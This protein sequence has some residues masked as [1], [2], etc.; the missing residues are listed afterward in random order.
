MT[1]SNAELL[2]ELGID[3]KHKHSGN[4]KT[5]CPKCGPTRKNKKDPCLSVDIDTGLYNCHHCDFKGRVF[6][7]PKKEFVRPPARLEKLSPKSLQW[8]ESVRGISNDTLLR[9]KVTESREWIPGL[10]GE[11]NCICFNYFRNDQ[12]INIKYR[13]PQKSFKMEKDAELIFYNLQAIDGKTTAVIVEGEIDCLTMVE[14]G[15]YDCVS[16]PNGAS[17]GNQRLEYLDNCWEYFDKKEKVVI[18]TDNDEAGIS[19][20]DELARRIGKDRCYTVEYPDGCKDTNEVY[21]KHGKEAVLQMLDNARLWPLEGI[22]STEDIFP[23]IVDWFE[24]GY[25]EGTRAGLQG[26]DDLLAFAP[27]EL[28]TITG[29]PG[30]GKDEYIN[31]VISSLAQRHGWKFGMFDFEETPPQTA[32]KLMEKISG[33]AFAFR[34]NPDD[35]MSR[36]GFEQAVAMVDSH[37]YFCNTDDIAPS[38]DMIISIATSL[39]LRFGIKGI[40]I[41]PWNWIEN[42]RPASMTETEYISLSLSK[43]IRFAR[44]YGV[45]VFLIAHTT[46]IQKDKRTGKYEIPNLYSISG[47]ANFYNKTHNGITVYRDAEAGTVDVY[48]QKV[49]QS[50]NGQTGWVSYTFNTFTRQYTLQSTSL[51]GSA[52]GQPWK[53]V[54]LFRDDDEESVNEE[55]T[56]QGGQPW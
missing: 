55:E 22:M 46:K 44:K 23:V 50:W 4:L 19:L 17:K 39:V 26:L 41:N 15:I 8:F 10:Q 35:R 13:G 32:T 16:V 29:I 5:Q 40:R 56:T 12:L 1:M 28:T 42:N 27:G 11:V 18:A 37:F 7:K 6:E 31:L 3:L 24:N 49:K 20:R 45:H 47:S 38:I 33:K 52:A 34:R 53:P 14:C 54:S 25:P 30:H 51:S 48:V 21:I 2:Q 43:I 36:R 9:M